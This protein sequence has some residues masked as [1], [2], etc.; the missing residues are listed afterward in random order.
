MHGMGMVGGGG[1]GWGWNVYGGKLFTTW[2]VRLAR[3]GD[4]GRPIRMREGGFPAVWSG[5][6]NVPIAVRVHT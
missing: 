1:S 2:R 4:D 5:D 3:F 6:E